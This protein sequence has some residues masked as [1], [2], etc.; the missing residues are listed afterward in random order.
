MRAHMRRAVA[1]LGHFLQK[2]AVRVEEER[3]P[4]SELVH[5]K[6]SVERG[7][8]VGD[9]VAQRERHF[10]HRGRAGLAH[11]ISG[12]GNRVPVGHVLVGPGKHVGDDAHGLRNRINVGAARDVFF[13]DVVLHGTGEMADV[14]TLAA[15]DGDVQR[16]Q[17]G[18]RGVDGHGSG[19]L[20]E[21]NAVEEALH[22]FDRVNG[23]TDFADFAE[24]KRIVGVEADLGGQIEGDG[25][26]S[27]AV[28]H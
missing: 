4:R 28:G 3:K 24:R 27:G 6:P 10:L 5:I 15:G 17:D 22:V 25:K 11:V 20:G 2:I 19:N 8:H 14:G 18:S 21:V 1:E 23:Y 16:Q 9:A 26:A 13:E 7:L 12:N